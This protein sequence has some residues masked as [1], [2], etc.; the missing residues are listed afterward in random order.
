M[1][2]ILQCNQDSSAFNRLSPDKIW[3]GFHP[4][5]FYLAIDKGSTELVA[6]MIKMAGAE[7][8]LDA[9]VKQSGVEE[10]EPPKVS[11]CVNPNSDVL[12]FGTFFRSAGAS[13]NP[14]ILYSITKV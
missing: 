3:P 11:V 12:S 2:F 7:L 14:L 5:D 1:H 6:E 8:P 9:L 10:V 13:V 4:S